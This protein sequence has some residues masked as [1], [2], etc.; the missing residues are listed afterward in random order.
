MCNIWLISCA[1]ERSRVPLWWTPIVSQRSFQKMTW[2]QPIIC[3]SLP[4][5]LPSQCLRC[6]RQGA[7]HRDQ[8]GLPLWPR[9]HGHGRPAAP[10]QYTWDTYLLMWATGIESD[11]QYGSLGRADSWS[12]TGPSWVRRM[13]TRWDPRGRW[14]I[15]QQS[16]NTRHDRLVGYGFI[17]AGLPMQ[18]AVV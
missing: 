13:R 15:S 4:W 10:E 11:V 12:I 1:K 5:S 14:L 9:L 16:L 3:H 18:H 17:L 6:Q 7:V 8:L 2:M